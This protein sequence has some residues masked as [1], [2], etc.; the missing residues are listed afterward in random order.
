MLSPANPAPSLGPPRAPAAAVLTAE[1]RLL[2]QKA[3]QRLIRPNNP[4]FVLEGFVPEFPVG[5]YLCLSVSDLFSLTGTKLSWGGENGDVGGG[6]WGAGLVPH[7]AGCRVGGRAGRA[8]RGTGGGFGARGPCGDLPQQP[9]P[10]VF[11]PQP[12]RSRWA[13]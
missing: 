7:L 12:A 4:G 8:G 11:P 3:P 10:P 1:S 2:G 5:F 6:G 13:H 9:G